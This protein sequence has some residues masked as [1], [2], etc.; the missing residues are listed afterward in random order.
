[1]FLTPVIIFPSHDTL[2]CRL[3]S[4]RGSSTYSWDKSRSHSHSVYKQSKQALYKS[5]TC[6]LADL[7]TSYIIKEAQES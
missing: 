3:S 7:K 2:H 1:M 6:I 5:L 4:H